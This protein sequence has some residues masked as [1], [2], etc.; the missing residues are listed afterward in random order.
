MDSYIPVNIIGKG[1]EYCK[2]G[3][4]CE[5]LPGSIDPIIRSQNAMIMLIGGI[6]L[7]GFVFIIF[8]GGN[9]KRKLIHA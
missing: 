3:E 9:R 1:I 4:I 7:V 6:V 5:A 2:S 8:K